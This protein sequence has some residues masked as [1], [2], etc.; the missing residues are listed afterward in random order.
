MNEELKA[1][2]IDF[3]LQILSIC[4]VF[5]VLGCVLTACE[6]ESLEYEQRQL[7]NLQ[8]L[9]CPAYP[10]LNNVIVHSVEVESSQ[11]SGFPYSNRRIVVIHAKRSA[12]AIIKETGEKITFNPDDCV[13]VQV[14]PNT[15]AE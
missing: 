7:A 5:A 9:T 10:T 14:L 12:T 3:F 15:N 6:T 13:L 11:Q 4:I 1:N 8:R 2:L